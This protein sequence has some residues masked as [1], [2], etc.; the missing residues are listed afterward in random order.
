MKIYLSG[1]MSGVP[2]Q[3]QPLFAD[4][5]RHLRNLGHEVMSPPEMDKAAGA[6]PDAGVV[7]G[8]ERARQEAFR[9]DFQTLT[10]W[11]EAIVMLPD[12]ANSIGA[13]AEYVCAYLV[14]LQLFE[15][16]DG[17]LEWI[18]NEIPDVYIWCRE[19]TDG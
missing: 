19:K 6:S 4:V 13:K 11:A 5:A 18:E 3:N 16:I 8:D 15:W 10:A 12:W 9:R 2:E 1:P 14:G 7:G 17:R